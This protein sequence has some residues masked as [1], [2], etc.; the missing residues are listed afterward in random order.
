MVFSFFEM[1]KLLKHWK[2]VPDGEFKKYMTG[3]DSGI[4]SESSLVSSISGPD[5]SQ[6]NLVDPRTFIMGDTY[7]DRERIQG[8][9]NALS[10]IKDELKKIKESDKYLTKTMIS[11]RSNIKSL[12]IGKTLINDTGY[13]SD[14]E[15]F[16]KE[17]KIRDGKRWL[18]AN[19]KAFPTNSNYF[20][21]GKRATWVI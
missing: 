20:D 17:D 14:N 5:I 1:N 8:I 15:P 7:S 2:S 11:I 6:S 16:Y 3:E 10:W 21:K 4:D 9:N 13:N 19:A 18:G 12:K